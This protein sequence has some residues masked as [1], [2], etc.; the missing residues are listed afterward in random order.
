M[1]ESASD[2]EVQIMICDYVRCFGMTI[3]VVVREAGRS[4]LFCKHDTRRG[5]YSVS[6][7]LASHCAIRISI[8]T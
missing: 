3:I 8:R 7:I 1:V 6:L 4:R 2:I 5:P